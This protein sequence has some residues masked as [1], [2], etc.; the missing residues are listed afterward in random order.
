M[1]IR[2]T[3]EIEVPGLGAQIREARKR[4]SRSLKLICEEVGI[5]KVYWYDIEKE[6]VRDTLPIET[7]RKIEKALDVDFGV[8]FNQGET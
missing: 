3:I 2:K 6:G 1:K 5:S 7:L 8:R 4:D